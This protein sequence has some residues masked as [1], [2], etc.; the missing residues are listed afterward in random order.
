MPSNKKMQS[1]IRPQ[2]I[3]GRVTS[4]KNI[5]TVTVLV[6]KTRTH[7]LYK[8]SYK[9]RKKYLAHVELSVKE[10]DIVEMIKVRPI[11]KR[12]HWQVIKV[13]GQDLEAIVSEQLKT[14]SGEAIAQVLPAA[15]IKI[16][17]NE[18]ASNPSAAEVK[19]K[20]AKEKKAT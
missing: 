14:K 20:K 9:Q 19:K 6:D 10:G 7:P 5:K 2:L 4:A 3:R 12:K 8:K 18:P 1:N 13:V 17:S 15:E 11:S 16:K